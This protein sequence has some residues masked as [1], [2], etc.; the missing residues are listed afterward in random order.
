MSGLTTHVLDAVRGGAAPG[1]RIDLAARAGANF[2][3]VKSV[4]TGDDGRALVLDA[5]GLAAGDYELTFHVAAYFA[6]RG[7]GSAEPVFL[8][9]VPVRFAVADP[10]QHYHIPLIVSP[11]TY[12]TYRGG[13]PPNPA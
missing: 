5:G 2:R 4:E 8:D 3:F 11:W 12:S 13:L 6:R 9:Q 7:R 10:S 1:V